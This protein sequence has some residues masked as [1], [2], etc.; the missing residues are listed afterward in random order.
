MTKQSDQ[1]DQAR[2][3]LGS[4]NSATNLLRAWLGAYSVGVP[5][6]LFTHDSALTKLVDH[7]AAAKVAEIFALAI[8][9]QVAITLINKYVEWGV[10]AR[11]SPPPTRNWYTALC[12]KASE[13]IW[14]DLTADLATI[15]L[16]VW[17][18]LVVF[19]VLV[20]P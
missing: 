4:Y 6:F 17:G 5:A 2:D 13:W 18:S 9:F 8:A 19:S 15:G 7:N 1:T 3:F 20:S 10:Y 12:E 14:L 16:L 11:H